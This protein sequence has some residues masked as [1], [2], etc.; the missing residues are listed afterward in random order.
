MMVKI[1]TFLDTRPDEVPTESN[2]ILGFYHGKMARSNMHNQICWVVAMEAAIKA[3]KS[4]TWIKYMKQRKKVALMDF[5]CGSINGEQPIGLFRRQT[6]IKPISRRQGSSYV[7]I[8]AN[9]RSSN[10]YKPGDLVCH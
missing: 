1:E 10:W 7:L 6:A 4:K 3:G 5:A 9:L 8:P 2:F